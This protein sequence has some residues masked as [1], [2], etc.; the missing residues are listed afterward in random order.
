MPLLTHNLY[1]MRPSLLAHLRWVCWIVLLPALLCFNIL[2]QSIFIIIV[3]ESFGT[4]E[5]D[6]MVADL[7]R[8]RLN[9]GHEKKYI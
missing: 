6:T 4:L 2:M 9:I 7:M 8:W 1:G 3:V 5:L